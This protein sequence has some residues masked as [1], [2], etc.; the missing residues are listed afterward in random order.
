MTG[1]WILWP[2]R[3]INARLERLVLSFIGHIEASRSF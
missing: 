3:L 1:Y 2:I